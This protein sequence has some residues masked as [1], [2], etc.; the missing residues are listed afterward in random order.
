DGQNNHK[1]K[2]TTPVL[3]NALESAGCFEATV[4]TSPDNKAPK[5][6]WNDWHPKFSDYA[7]VVS[8]YNGQDWPEAVQK[9][10][11]AFVKNGG[12]FVSV[13]AADNSFPKWQ[14]YND[15]IGVG[16]W[17]GRNEKSGPWLYMQDGKVVKDE[18]PGSGGGHGKQHEF[19]VEIRNPDHPI[20]KGL[21]AKWMQAQ[22]ELYSKLRGPAEVEILS[23]S[24]S[25]TTGKDEPNLI[26]R[27]YDKGRVAHITLG[28]ADYS[29][30]NRGFYL[31]FQRSTEWAATGTVKATAE[32]PKDFPTDKVVPIDLEGHPPVK[33]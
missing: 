2:E 11:E 4:S 12:G 25:D 32:V 5:E 23:T 9:D 16:G 8:N 17:G 26:V 19:Y 24:R 29:M 33:K 1:W 18:S 15:M 10:F 27:N 21:P 6:A 3:V 31:I 28:H 14:A 20:T 22:D 7:V 30:L 13:H